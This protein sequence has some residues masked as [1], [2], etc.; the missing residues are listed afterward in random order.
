MAGSTV[1]SEPTLGF[2]RII[3]IDA[4]VAEAQP[5]LTLVIGRTPFTLFLLHV[6][7]AARI[8]TLVLPAFQSQ[9]IG[10]FATGLAISLETALHLGS[11]TKISQAPFAPARVRLAFRVALALLAVIL[12]AFAPLLGGLVVPR[13]AFFVQADRSYA[14]VFARAAR[15]F[16]CETTILRSVFKTSFQNALP[17]PTVFRFTI[18]LSCTSLTF[19]LSGRSTCLALMKKTECHA[20]DQKRKERLHSRPHR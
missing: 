10:L 17:V 15:A 13:E 11:C 18:F 8:A 14:V 4:F 19:G 5:R 6:A 3:G 2:G 9:A 20:D 1:G 7:D 12:L 16:G